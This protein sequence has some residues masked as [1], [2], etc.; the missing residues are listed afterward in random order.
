MSKLIFNSGSGY[1]DK[2]YKGSFKVVSDNKTKFFNSLLEA[3]K[4]YESLNEPKGIWDITH[5]PELL[6][7]H[8]Y[9]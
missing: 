5:L 9:N 2:D 3:V 6:A 1:S 4:Y 8:D 7:C